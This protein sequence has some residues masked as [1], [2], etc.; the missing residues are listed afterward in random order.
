MD[1][2]TRFDLQAL[3]FIVMK[4]LFL[5][6]FHKKQFKIVYV[7]RFENTSFNNPLNLHFYLTLKNLKT[8]C[9][10]SITF[11]KKKKKKHFAKKDLS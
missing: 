3:Y 10:E 11:F 2:L 1:L 7:K 5:S 9:V 8:F 4:V 6:T